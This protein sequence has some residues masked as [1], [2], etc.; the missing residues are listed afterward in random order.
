MDARATTRRGPGLGRHRRHREPARVSPAHLLAV[1]SLHAL[2]E[3]FALFLP[4][5][6]W[7][8]AGRHGEWPELLAATFVTVAIAVPPLLLA[9]AVEVWGTPRLLAGL[10]RASC[11]T[12]REKTELLR[13]R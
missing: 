13:S 6:A 7:T 4:L 9:G 10:Q 3:L 11:R 1:V 12:A 2:P 8:V 5:A